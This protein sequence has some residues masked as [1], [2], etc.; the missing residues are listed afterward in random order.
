MLTAPTRDPGTDFEPALLPSL[1]Q[2]KC[3]DNDIRIYQKLV[4]TLEMVFSVLSNHFGISVTRGLDCWAQ[5]I[6]IAALEL[7]RLSRHRAQPE[8]LLSKLAQ[9]PGGVDVAIACRVDAIPVIGMTRRRQQRWRGLRIDHLISGVAQAPANVLGKAASGGGNPV[10]LGNC[11]LGR[12]VAVVRAGSGLGHSA[13]PVG[14]FRQGAIG[15]G[16]HCHDGF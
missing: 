16:I 6:D 4:D 9:L 2:A 3:E 14:T 7:P 8:C 5:N 11:P 15:I 12:A 1:G 10:G 13:A